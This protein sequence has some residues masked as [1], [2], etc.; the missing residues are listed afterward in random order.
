MAIPIATA[1]LCHGRGYLLTCA[2]A[3]GLTDELAIIEP[4][5][6]DDFT[7]MSLDRVVPLR[8]GVAQYDPINDVALLRISNQSNVQEG[9]VIPSV[10]EG[11]TVVGATAAYLGYPFSDLGLVVRHIALTTVS[12]KVLSE[13]GVKQFQLDAMIHEG[14]SGGPVIDVQT[15]R[16]FGIVAG[17]FAPGRKTDGFVITKG[18]R[19]LGSD[20]G[21]SYATS[22]S[23]GL[24]L[25]RAEGLNA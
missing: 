23:Y 9:F 11:S 19:V 6:V 1:F 16:V 17:R 12:S 18:G 25:M 8:V 20:S 3:L 2:H 13:T 4:S 22:I 24:E 15:G 10:D 14:C 7:P 5:S 21:I